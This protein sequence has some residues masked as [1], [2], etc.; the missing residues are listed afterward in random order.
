MAFTDRRSGAG[1]A[2][3]EELAE[4]QHQIECV[5]SALAERRAELTELRKEL[6]AFQFEYDAR[7]GHTAQELER[8]KAELDRCR[9][10]IERYRR[11]GPG[12]PPR[13]PGGGEYVPVDEQYRRTWR[14]PP[15]PPQGVRSWVEPAA[16]DVEERIRQLYRRLCRQ[17][18]PD[19]ARDSE[20]QR[21]RTEAMAAINAAY[22]ARLQD[23]Q[24]SLAQL[25]DLAE[26]A[27]H[28]LWEA[29]GTPSQRLA[30]LQGKLA[31]L[32]RQLG[33]VEREIR[34]LAD[35]PAMRA[36]L[37]VKLARR[38]G[39]DLLSE[40]EQ[41]VAKELVR[42]QAELEFMQAQLRDLGLLTD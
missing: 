19:L 38:Y 16:A 5:R 22:A 23:P 37:E 26:S 15:E 1:K 30:A 17:F 20:D 13:T 33:E 42:R 27:L 8:V 31:R 29:T 25:S 2:I 34:E 24:E 10:Q 41:D 9:R 14:E 40:M 7:V 32:E 3:S 36:S 28:D 4:L 18:H 35:S 6:S 12:G 39:R 11:W 21:R